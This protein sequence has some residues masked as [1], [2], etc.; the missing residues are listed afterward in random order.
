[1]AIIAREVPLLLADIAAVV[2]QLGWLCL[3]NGGNQCSCQ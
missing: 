3:G 2:S 1:M